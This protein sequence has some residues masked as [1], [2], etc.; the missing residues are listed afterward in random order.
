[1]KLFVKRDLDGFFGLFI[2]NLVQFLVIISFCELFCGMTGE[3]SRFL[4]KMILPGAAI[5]ILVGNLFYAW[6]AHRLARKTGR[7]D[8]TALPYGIN[9]PSIIVYIFFVMGPEFQ[10]TQS[11]EAAWKMGLVACLGSG[12]IE[13]VGSFVAEKLRRNTPRAALLSTLAGIAIGFIAMT[14][15]LQIFQKP[16]IAM[17]P[18][19]LVLIGLFSQIRLPLGLPS[20]LLAVTLGTALAW[21]LMLLQRA[22]PSAPEWLTFGAASIDAV[23]AATENVGLSL[24]VWSGEAIWSVAQNIQEIL[25]LLSVIIP[26]GL[27][28]VVGSLQNIESAEAAGDSYPTAPSMAANGIGTIV[29]ALFGSCFPTTIYIGHPGWKSLGARAGYSTL[30]GVVI[31]ALTLTGLI[32]LVAGIVPI[33]VGAGI[34]LWIGV[35]ITAQAFRAVPEN[36]APAVA[37]GLFPAIAAWGAV[38]MMGTLMLAQGNSLQQVISPTVEASEVKAND[39]SSESV[40]KED[41]K[42]VITAVENPHPTAEVNGFL[43]HGLLL[44]ERGYIFTCMI[45]AAVSACLV[46]RKFIAAGVWMLCA[47]ALTFLGAMHAYQVYNGITFDFLFRFV[48]PVAGGVYYRANDLAISYLLCGLLFIGLSRWANSQP[49]QPHA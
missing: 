46:D 27:F 1:M 35:I 48:D 29:A 33:E 7:D 45:L 6:Q 9:T 24:P 23:K 44:M 25:P 22:V 40:Q 36:H 30:N 19:A 32:S 2:D 28:N 39:V 20:G 5:S 14:F 11:A 42:K 8:V 21:G 47:S 41:P 13:L 17:L 34:V 10:K 43:V 37:V 3:N 38:V 4:Y 26:M 18:L 31:V 12:V 15:T 16:L 49:V